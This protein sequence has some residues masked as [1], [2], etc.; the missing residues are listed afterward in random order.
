MVS[1]LPGEVKELFSLAA[2]ARMPSGLKAALR[3]DPP[4]FIEN[5]QRLLTAGGAVLGRPENEVLF[6]TGFNKNDTAPERFEAALAEL[7]AVLWLHQEGFTGITLLR[8][9]SGT[10]ADL[11]GTLGNRNYI[12]EVRCIRTV[13]AGPLGYLFEKHESPPEPEQRVINYLRLKYEKKIRQVNSSRKKTGVNCGGVII[14]LAPAG[15]MPCPGAPAL[16][17]L[18]G[19][20]YL[21]KNSPPLTHIGLLAGPAGA[22]FPEWQR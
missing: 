19:A 6:I 2:R 17:K 9:S 16:K 8:Q 15:L 3:Q 20:L 12:F 22:V 7:R 1:T 21:A 18:A 10:G 14:V 11:A 4:V 13:A 5:M